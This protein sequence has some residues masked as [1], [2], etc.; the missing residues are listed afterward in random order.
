MRYPTC[1]K[2]IPTLTAIY[3]IESGEV[4]LMKKWIIPCNPDYYDVLGAFN[5]FETINWKQSIDIQVGDTVYIYV[6]TPIRA[7][8]FEAKAVKVDL[9]KPIVDDHNYVI[10]G[11][12]YECYG[13]YMELQ[14]V[15]TFDDSLLPYSLL[16][17][18]GLKTVQGPSKV[19]NTLESFILNQTAPI[20]SALERRYFF[21]FQNKNYNKEFDGGYLCAPKLTENGKRKSH[22]ERMKEI[23]SG[24]LIIHSYKK[25]ILA[26]SV[27][28][29]NVYLSN[30]PK[31]YQN[32]ENREGWRV[33]TKYYPIHTPI[34]TS[35]HIKVLMALQPGSNAPFNSSGKGNTG[36]L[37]NATKKMAEYIIHESAKLQRSDLEKKLLLSLLS[38]VK[39]SE[40]TEKELDRELIEEINDVSYNS[41]SLEIPYEPQPKEKPIVTISNGKTSYAR[42]R[43][44][45][46]NALNRA[47]HNCEVNKDHPGFI[48]KNTQM[49]Y[50]EPHHLIP[51]AYQDIFNYSLDVEANIVALCSNCHNQIHYGSEY[52]GLLDILYTARKQQL[53]K[54]GISISLEDLLILY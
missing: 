38:D 51:M 53:D 2:G 5:E 29:K 54:A 44:T 52:K 31:E 30:I 33:D 22:W 15:R 49:N 25:Q 18:N 42:N 50:T 24:D 3:I 13:R 23:R 26:I 36:Y 41:S 1:Y 8:K 11:L 16:R 37:F 32:Q 48:R 4:L 40:M 46:Q 35:D 19:S 39:E 10:D 21:V 12:R 17:D 28:K 47:Q 7:I 34:V 45:A 9:D 6:S 14:L 20:K 27:A 43:A